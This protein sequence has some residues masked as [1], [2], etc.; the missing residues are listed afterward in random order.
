MN[1]ARRAILL[2]MLCIAPLGVTSA[3]AAGCDVPQ[4]L[5]DPTMQPRLRRALAGPEFRVLI[6]GSASAEQGGSA[7]RY[8]ERLQALLREQYPGLQV[9]VEARGRRGANALEILALIAPLLPDFRPHLVLWQT[10]TVEAVRGLPIEAM[11]DTLS[12]GIARLRAAGAEVMVMDPQFSRFL[13]AN[14]DID[15]YRDAL[16]LTAATEAVPLLRRWDWM[17]EWADEGVL[18]VER[19]PAQ[20]RPVTVARL[21]DCVAR[22][23]LAQIQLSTRR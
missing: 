3:W 1:M 22:G 5:L 9:R 2:L 11:T 6:G 23:I 16:R 21:H 20:T 4:D 8:P 13:R 12:T 15:A 10:G 17:R 18:D 14:A 19:A 7:E